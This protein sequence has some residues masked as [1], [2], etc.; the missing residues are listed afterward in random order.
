[1]RWAV[2]GSQGKFGREEFEILKAAGEDVTGFDRVNLNLRSPLSVIEKALT[3]FDIVVNAVAYTDVENAEA[4]AALAQFA[5]VEVPA[6][7]ARV[8]NE[9]GSRLIHIS[10]D[11]VFDGRRNTPYPIFADKNPINYYG[12]TKAMGEDMVLDISKDFCVI[13]AAWLYGAQGKSFPKAIAEKLLLTGSAFV[14]NDELGQPT[15]VRDFA[16][17][18]SE[19]AR[20]NAVSPIAHVASSG[21]ASRADFAKEVAISLGLGH[22]AIVGIAGSHSEGVRRPKNSVLQLDGQNFKQLDNWRNRWHHSSKHLIQDWVK[23]LTE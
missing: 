11:Y 7:L 10:T 15:W 4:N 23:E 5:N 22:E 12:K 14:V 3:G 8:L 6:K 1:M 17:K 2:L 9:T 19:I 18:V 20:A 13:R 16:C 21:A